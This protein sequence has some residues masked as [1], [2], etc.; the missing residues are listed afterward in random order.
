MDTN[1]SAGWEPDQAMKRILYVGTYTASRPGEEHRK[2][3]IYTYTFDQG[4]GRLALSSAAVSGDNPSFLAVSPDRRF[5]FSVNEK[6]DGGVSSFSI[7]QATGALT[8]LN[9]EPTRGADPCYLST[10][11]AG[12]WLLTANYSGGS[13]CVHPIG[14]DGRLGPMSDF[15]QHEGKG[16]NP[17]RQEKA[18]AHSIRFAPGGQFVLAADLG[19]DSVLIYRLGSEGKLTLH[20]KAAFAPGT[21][22]RHFDYHPNGGFIYVAGELASSITA[23]TWDA[24]KGVLTPFQS[25]ST[26]PAGFSGEN[27]V[28]DIHVHP[29]G[30][31]VVVSNRGHHSLAL[32]SIDPA[33]GSLALVGHEPTRGAWPRN[34]AIDPDGEYLLA[35][36]Q[37]TDNIVTFRID[38]SS[39][40]LA[41]TGEETHVP[42]PVCLR[43]IDL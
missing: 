39:G 9:S 12:R 29:S 6:R 22:P 2:E 1:A 8:R 10:D 42:S 25:L 38:P 31:W 23:C 32:F 37:Y 34:F 4:S 41:A 33:S 26:L 28:A 27:I 17:A 15:I 40:R 5:L 7:D 18:H 19:L 35:A 16:P 20:G 24:A 36:N 14:P 21:G 3:G 11:P 13:L 30:R 43:F